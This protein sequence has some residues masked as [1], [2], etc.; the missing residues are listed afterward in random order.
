MDMI[1]G[2]VSDTHDNLHGWNSALEIFQREKV[3]LILHCGDILE[4]HAKAESSL[5]RAMNS[6]PI[7]VL[8]VRGNVDA[9][10]HVALL[11]FPVVP[12]VLVQ[13]GPNRI[14]AVHGNLL[15]DKASAYRQATSLSARFLVRGHTHIPE[16]ERKNGVYLLNPGSA[17]SPRGFSQASV[18]VLSPERI[19]LI[20]LHSGEIIKDEPLY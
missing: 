9:N 5:C 7:P 11:N 14:I 16:I 13:D 6:S 8:A 12:L 19:K 20:A 10:D 18:M 2:I 15:A 17:G 1:I 3:E 4:A